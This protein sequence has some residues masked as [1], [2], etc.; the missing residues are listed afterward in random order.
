MAML[1]SDPIMSSATSFQAALSS[2]ESPCCKGSK[3][4]WVAKNRRRGRES[5][6]T[7]ATW[8][9]AAPSD[10]GWLVRAPGHRA[11]PAPDAFFRSEGARGGGRH[12]LA[13]HTRT[14]W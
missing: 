10:F 12:R 14:K 1:D 8:Q 7:A 3:Q 5:G 4:D 2:G 9:E 13:V 6:R 11:Q